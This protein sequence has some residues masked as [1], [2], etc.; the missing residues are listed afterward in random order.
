MFVAQS[1]GAVQFLKSA[2]RG[3]VLDPPQSTSVSP[4]FLTPS[5]QLAATHR[6]ALQILLTQSLVM[7]QR[8]PFAQAAHIAPPQSTSVS[9]AFILASA[10]DEQVFAEQRALL[11]SVGTVH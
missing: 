10:H 1:D 7:T 9:S 6:L 2:Q 5:V 8:L 11:Q 4:W 3:Q